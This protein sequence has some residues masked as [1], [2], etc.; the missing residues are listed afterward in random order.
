MAYSK[1][2][3]KNGQKWTQDHIAHIEAGIIANEAE[4]EKK[5]LKTDIPDISGLQ[6][7]GD[8]LTEHQELKTINGQSIVGSGNLEISGDGSTV[9]EDIPSYWTEHLTEKLATINSVNEAAGYNGASLIFLTDTHWPANNNYSIDL[10]NKVIDGTSIKKVFFGGDMLECD[11]KDSSIVTL[12]REK[13]KKLHKEAILYPVRG[14]HDTTSSACKDTH[15]WDIFYSRLANRNVDVS[16]M[17]YYDDD[18]SHKI[19]YIILDMIAPESAVTTYFTNQLNWME[20]RVKELDTGWNVVVVCHS[21]WGALKVGTITTWGQA[22]LD[23]LDALCG[24]VKANIIAVISGHVHDDGE[25]QR[26]KGYVVISTDAD[27]AADGVAGG[28]TEQAFDVMNINVDTKKI[29]ITRVGRGSDRSISYVLN[30]NESAAGGSGSGDSSTDTNLTTIDI[31]S[32][33]DFSQSGS[34]NYS[35]GRVVNDTNWSHNEPV[36]VS[37][38]EQLIL[39]LPTSG[40]DST[41]VGYAFYNE[42]NQYV[43]G[44]SL[45]SGTVGE[46]VEKTITI[47]VPANATYFKTS[48][49]DSDYDKYWSADWEFVAKAT[50]A[51]TD[52]EVPDAGDEEEEIPTE[53]VTTDITS[54]FNFSNQGN[55]KA[56]DGTIESGDTN[57][58]HT[59]YVDVSAYD[60]LTATIT[61]S[62]NQSTGVGLA[63][64]NVN[65]QFVSGKSYASGTAG[66]Y[67]LQTWEIDVPANA[68]YIRMSTMTENYTEYYDPT[69]VIKI[70]GTGEVPVTTE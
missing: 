29:T 26:A 27:R 4:L 57:W 52:I 6:P 1:L 65:K 23:R 21:V 34:I 42:T 66:V 13:E 50:T 62:G 43:S 16:K 31:T 32:L 24:N 56:I 48:L 55:V 60:K 5:A 7:K 15:W 36:D 63:F 20:E 46:Y 38:Y 59:D 64:Y 35:T 61:T 39:T 12:G 47:D 19:R 28:I 58:A 9:V 70:A 49:M 11:N 67:E 33:F 51:E 44:A 41:T 40:N 37:S 54:L 45:Y 68:T 69:W 53:T 18:V 10:I 22:L 8:Y 2:N 14:N 17:Y 25:I 30:G 3:L